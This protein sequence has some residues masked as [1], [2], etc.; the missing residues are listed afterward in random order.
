MITLYTF[1]P[2][3]GLP[4]PS[5][6][7]LKG[8]VLMKMSGQAFRTDTHGF[9][10]A[11]KHK[12]PYIDDNGKKVADS[13][14]IRFYLEQQYGID[15][16]NGYSTEQRAQAWAVEKMLEEH[17]YFIGA[18][19]RWIDDGN[20][21]RGPAI[22]FAKIPQPMR[23]LIQRVIRKKVGK[24]LYAQGIGRHSA[25][26][27]ETLAKRDLDV[28]ATLLGDKPYLLGDTP[29][30]T[31]ATLYGMLAVFLSPVIES[32][33]RTHAETKRNLVDYVARMQ[34][35]YFPDFKPA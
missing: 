23:A 15:F 12:L 14:L 25:T 31:D 1:G 32:P 26:E 13:T 29:C 35:Q 4:D 24:M 20:F 33:I 18:W 8:H 30:G 34:A 6:F 2:G 3:M 21:Q 19:T 10:Q 9:R 28:V 22:F 17:L 5:P 16:D 11:P 7:V 27:I